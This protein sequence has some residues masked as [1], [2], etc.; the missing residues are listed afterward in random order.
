MWPTIHR[1]EHRLDPFAELNRLHRQMNRLFH[2]AMDQATEFP[3]VNIR[4]TEDEVLVSAELAGVDPD[5]LELTVDGR[6]LTLAGERPTDMPQD[7]GVVYRHERQTGSFMR[8]VRLPFD[9]DQN[10]IAARYE[11]GILHITLPRSEA[12]KPRKIAISS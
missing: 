6:V 7:A 11:H 8:T 9:V 12:T 4:G 2:T 5:K 10:R 1:V 3:P